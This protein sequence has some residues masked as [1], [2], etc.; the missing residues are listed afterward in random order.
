MFSKH[1]FHPQKIT[2]K[3]YTSKSFNIEYSNNYKLLKFCTS[4]IVP[5]FHRFWCMTVYVNLEYE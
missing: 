3:K 2:R 4:P 1:H 5:Q